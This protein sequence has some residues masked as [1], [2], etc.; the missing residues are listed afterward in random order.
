MAPELS[1]LSMDQYMGVCVWLASLSMGK[2]YA[3]FLQILTTDAVCAAARGRQEKQ[4]PHGAVQALT[5]YSTCEPTATVS[6]IYCPAATGKVRAS[7]NYRSIA[8][9]V[10]CR[11]TLLQIGSARTRTFH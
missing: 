10:A 8:M 9:T 4:H 6:S 3:I 7:A 11:P 1:K 5:R 2:I